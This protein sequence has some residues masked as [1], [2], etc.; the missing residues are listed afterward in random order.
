VR[1]A[2]FERRQVDGVGE[3]LA[4][5]GA[6]KFQSLKVGALKVP[7]VCETRCWICSGSSLP[8]LDVYA[9]DIAE[10]ARSVLSPERASSEPCCAMCSSLGYSG[11]SVDP[12]E[13]R[14]EDVAAEGTQSRSTLM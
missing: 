11:T 12:F 9:G 5:V 10:S 2:G 13:A 7:S 3:A 8:T 6:S 1:G 4:D 14:A